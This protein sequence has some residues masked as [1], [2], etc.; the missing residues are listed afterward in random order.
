MALLVYARPGAVV[1]NDKHFSNASV[2]VVGDAVREEVP[3]A[4]PS[5][6]LCSAPESSIHAEVAGA[7]HIDDACDLHALSSSAPCVDNMRS[8][9]PGLLERRRRSLQ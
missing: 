8:G 7:A 3:V 1:D 9:G 4:L 2:T 5:S 6:H